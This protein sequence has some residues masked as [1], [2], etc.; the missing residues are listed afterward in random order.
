MKREAQTRSGWHSKGQLGGSAGR[1]V[2]P[3]EALGRPRGGKGSVG[4]ERRSGTRGWEVRSL[5]GCAGGSIKLPRCPGSQSVRQTGQSGSGRRRKGSQFRWASGLHKLPEKHNAPAPRKFN[6][7]GSRPPPQVPVRNPGTTPRF[8]G[9]QN[10]IGRGNLGALASDTSERRA[11]SDSKSTGWGTGGTVSP[12]MYPSQSMT[13]SDHH[14][15]AP[16]KKLM[17]LDLKHRWLPT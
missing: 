9:R 14:H 4:L 13:G 16:P 15:F 10:D 2:C 6:R 17:Q 8:L 7:P 11:S 1:S 3:G 5:P 12:W